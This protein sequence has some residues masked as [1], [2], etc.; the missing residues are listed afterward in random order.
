MTIKNAYSLTLPAYDTTSHNINFSANIEGTTIALY[1]QWFNGQWNAWGILNGE[2]RL[3][4]VVP[5][6]MNWLNH[7]D[8]TL[9][10]NAPQNEIG[11][12]DLVNTKIWILK[13][14]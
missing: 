9:V 1:F 12:A 10:F 5:Y 2:T 14:S 4:G 7:Y 3:I 8:F 13:W 6:I 11:Q